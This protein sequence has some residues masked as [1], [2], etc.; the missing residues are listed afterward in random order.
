[1]L[2][3]MPTARPGAPRR[4][5]LALAPALGAALLASAAGAASEAFVRSSRPLGPYVEVQLTGGVEHALLAPASEVCARM[6]R[7]EARVSFV[8]RGF[9]GRMETGG[10]RCEA[11][12]ILVL[13]TWRDRLPRPRVPALPR[14][15]ARWQ[16]LHRDGRLALLRGRFPL[17]PLVGMAGAHDLV[18]VVADDETCRDVVE[19]QEGSLEYHAAGRVA[20][21]LAAGA[22]RCHVLGYARPPSGSRPGRSPGH[23]ASLGFASL[24]APLARRL[25]AWAWG[26]GR[27]R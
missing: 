26:W 11:A 23:P 14:K 13:E 9:P 10:E 1:M 21:R 5:P 18:A 4:L 22:S 17:A 8:W 15:T 2:S 12:G 24:R 16:L 20:Y 25:R 3:V 7:P 19:G 6:L 27:V